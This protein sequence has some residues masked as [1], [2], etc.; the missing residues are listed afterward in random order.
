MLALGRDEVEQSQGSPS[1]LLC[2]W[3]GHLGLICDYMV[4]RTDLLTSFVIPF[5]SVSAI[6]RVILISN[7]VFQQRITLNIGSF[8]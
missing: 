5:Y 8:A 1:E 4:D 2:W 6:Y 3:K 7:L